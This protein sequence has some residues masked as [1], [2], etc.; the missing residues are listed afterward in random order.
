MEIFCGMAFL[1]CIFALQG[2]LLEY[3]ISRYDLGSSD[4]GLAALLSSFGG[5]T[6]FVLALFLTGRVK[7]TR[8]LTA[9]I[10]LAAVFLGSLT[11]LPPFPLYIA[12]WFLTGIGMGL[13]DTL[14]SSCIADLYTGKEATEKMCHLHSTFGISSMVAPLIYS[15]LISRGIGWSWMYLIIALLGAVLTAAMLLTEKSERNGNVQSEERLTFADLRTVFRMGSL[16]YFIL[17][18]FCHGFFLGGMNNWVN[19]YVGTVLKSSFGA[20]ALTFMYSGVLA[21]RFLM[22]YVGIRPENLIRY[23]GFAA[24]AAFL[25]VLPFSGGRLF[26]IGIAVSSFC[27]GA[28]IPCLLNVAC[29]ETVGNTLVT[30][31]LMMLSLYLGQGIAPPVLGFC[32]STVGLRFGLL[33]CAFFMVLTSLI[34]VLKTKKKKMP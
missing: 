6:A 8:L 5:M 26:C 29:E 25:A 13:I 1:S 15:F 19:Y 21:A 18:M 20:A 34:F 32:E 12:L 30:T 31:S 24:A 16:P 10:A 2:S 9:G 27:F 17:A 33:L 11:V 28:I 23:A 4:Q 7:K 14:L 22:P 3:V